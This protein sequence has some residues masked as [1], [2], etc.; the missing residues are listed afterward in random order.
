MAGAATTFDYRKAP[1]QPVFLVDENGNSIATTAEKHLEVALH[2]P[3]TTFG[4][5][6]VAEK[7]PL[8]QQNF[9]YPNAGSTETL[10]FFTNSGAST[11][12]ANNMISCDSGTQTLALCSVRT[13]RSLVYHS[14]QGAEGMW[15]AKY[16]SSVAGSILFSGFGNAE[17][18]VGFTMNESGKFG[19]VRSSGGVR[20]VV[21]MVVDVKSSHAQ[22][23]TVTLNGTAFSC[24]VTN[25]ADTRVTTNDLG[26]CDFTGQYPGWVTEA[27]G[28]TITFIPTIPG[29]LTGTYSVAFST[30]GS[31]TFSTFATGKNP[32]VEFVEQ[33]AWNIDTLDGSG[34]TS[35]PSG[36]SLNPANL[37]VYG[38]G[39]QYLGGGQIVYKVQSPN[40]SGPEGEEMLP[41]HRISYAGREKSPSLSNPSMP[42]VLSARNV[43]VGGNLGISV[44]SVSAFTQG[45]HVVLGKGRSYSV[46]KTGLGTTY[47]PLLTIN[48][49]RLYGNRVNQSELDIQSIQIS[50]NGTKGMEIQVIEDAHLGNDRS[51]V[52]VST[53][54]SPARAD[55][56]ATTYSNGI[57]RVSRGIPAGQQAEIDA[58][59]FRMDIPAGSRIT[60]VGRAVS[61]TVDATISA[62]WDEDQ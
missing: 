5:V 60:I 7:T 61:T 10:T 18:A 11:S 19:I 39:F 49:S 52:Q 14:G 27:Q 58:A 17:T 22:I 32:A 38:I 9:V 40:A 31:G 4:E 1:K 30:S 3:I 34:S 13:N 25:G 51:W 8:I 55:F 57:V 29:P 43:G 50:N 42:F 16:S 20:H 53:N 6:K 46:S 35:N 47:V 37:Q 44:G 21:Q 23:A 26:V 12:T 54:T 41:V 59:K 33:N 15:T 28:S 24:L 36:L 62:Q 2:D 45:K 48:N 56:S